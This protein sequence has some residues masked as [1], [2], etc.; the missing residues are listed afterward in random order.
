MTEP[1]LSDSL[2]AAWLQRLTS[3]TMTLAAAAHAPALFKPGHLAEVATRRAR[4]L[5][6]LQGGAR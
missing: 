4:A 1:T 2:R 3:T 5:T 6:M